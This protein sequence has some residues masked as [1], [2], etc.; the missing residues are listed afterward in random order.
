MRKSLFFLLTTIVLA[1]C[2]GDDASYEVRSVSLQGRNDSM[3]YVV[4]FLQGYR[5]RYF[6]MGADTTEQAMIEFMD[7][8]D[9]GYAGRTA[10]PYAVRTIG[11]R[12]GQQVRQWEREGLTSN[13]AWRLDEGLL[14]QGLINSL[15]HDTVGM[16]PNEA[17]RWSQSRYD[18]SQRLARPESVQPA[19]TA[20][21]PY[22]YAPAELRTE[23]DSLNY[24]VGVINGYAMQRYVLTA[25]EQ[26]SVFRDFVDGVNEGLR[27]D[28]R[29]YR[30]VQYGEELGYGLRQQG[31]HLMGENALDID[32]TLIRQGLVNGLMGYTDM[33]DPE[34][35]EIYFRATMEDIRRVA[36][37]QEAEEAQQ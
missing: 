10:D 12:Q 20:T 4:S 16:Q 23:I 27:T 26:S 32:I 1:S 21:C 14:L 13:P 33:I 36:H 5:L 25:D 30:M 22:H 7:A 34:T 9:R 24:A 2:A 6:G 18:D 8:F 28:A 29:N 11:M 19:I 17:Y 37:E 31:A 3:N 35:A 15:L